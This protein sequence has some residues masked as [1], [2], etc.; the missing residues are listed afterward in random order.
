MKVTTI[1][2]SEI[3]KP[4]LS[5]DIHEQSSLISIEKDDFNW[6]LPTSIPDIDIV[7]LKHN[8]QIENVINAMSSI[9]SGSYYLAIIS[10]ISAALAAFLFNY[11][12]WRYLKKINRIAHFSNICISILNSFEDAS[13]NYWLNEKN[14][15]NKLD[16]EKLEIHISSTFRTLRRTTDVFCES[17]NLNDK[18]DSI[19]IKNIIKELFDASTGGEFE[20]ISRHSSKSVATSTT[21]LCCGAKSIL[22][23]HT[24]QV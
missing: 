9:P 14:S 1:S 12:N 4:P 20:A 16:M 21:I 2:S 5:F 17:L 23:K 3:F 19:K 13:L 24:Q 6:T 11:F 18:S 15:S 10:G 7:T 22:Y 8:E